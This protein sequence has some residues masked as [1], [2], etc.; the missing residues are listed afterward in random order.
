MSKLAALII[1]DGFACRDEEKGNAVSQAY[2]PNFDRYWNAHPHNQLQ[3]SGEDVGLPEGQMGN[4]EVGHLNI[5]AGRIVYQSLTRINKA[6]E[7]KSFFDNQAFLKAMKQ[8][9]QHDKALHLYGLLS[10][11]GVHSHIN[12]LFALLELAKQHEVKDVYVHAFLDGRD[13]DQKSALTYLDRLDAKM[14]ELEIGQLA[15]ISGRFYAM[16][17]DQR[18]PRVKLAYDAIR[19]GEGHKYTDY[20]QVIHDAYEKEIYDE[21]V[22]PSV[23]INEQGHPIGAVNDEDAIIFYNFRPD[24]AIQLSKAFANQDFEDFVLGKNTLNNIYFVQMTPYSEDVEGD[25]A[26]RSEDLT[27]TLGEVIANNDLKQLRIAETEKF[28]HVTYFMSGGREEPFTEEKRI[29][30]D[31]PKVATYD[32]KPE[33]SAYELTDSLLTELD[34]DDLHAVILNFANPDMVG[35]SG[36]LEPT[37]KA[38]EV[39]DECLGKI[40]DKIVAKGGEVIITADHGNS[41]EVVT[42]NGNPMTTHTTNPVPVI[43]TKEGASIRDGGRLADLAPTMLDLLEINQ[44]EAMTGESLIIKTE[45]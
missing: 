14:T 7:D 39:V 2:K 13:V 34:R 38:I 23:I 29:L 32:L 17:R 16:D 5:G 24:R 20:R 12:H 3:V 26:Y 41:D 42:E 28:P 8:V 9:K 44:P 4:S 43:V 1:L 36:M 45:K 19:S 18:W 27:E 11:G 35:H 33:M 30:I 31:S 25:I 22:E 15:T 10:D 40:V 21:F 37:I 6:I